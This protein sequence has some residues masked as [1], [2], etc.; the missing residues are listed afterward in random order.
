MWKRAIRWI[1][2]AIGSLSLVITLS[3]HSR[4]STTRRISLF[5]KRRA[6]RLRNHSLAPRSL[7]YLAP[8]AAR[9]ISAT[10]NSDGQITGITRGNLTQSTTYDA[11][12][13]VASTT[14]MNAP[15]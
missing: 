9:R 13:R 15:G 14:D 4:R 3:F 1:R 11:D 10:Y 8:W 7:A 6:S 12:G 2:I 5:A